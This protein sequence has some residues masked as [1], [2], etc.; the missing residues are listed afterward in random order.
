MGISVNAVSF[1][2]PELAMDALERS[3]NISTSFKYYIWFPTYREIRQIPRFKKFIREIG[4]VDYW[5]KYGWPDI[6]HKLDNGD[7]ECD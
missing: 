3:Y 7:L 1:G 6:C 4:L 5:N 2:D